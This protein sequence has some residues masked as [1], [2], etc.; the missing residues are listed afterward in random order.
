MT[1]IQSALE[2]RVSFG[3]FPY[4]FA[5]CFEHSFHLIFLG[6]VHVKRS[7]LFLIFLLLEIHQTCNVGNGHCVSRDKLSSV[8]N[9]HCVGQSGLFSSGIELYVS[10][11]AFGT[12]LDVNISD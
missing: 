6:V 5:G 1:E 8:G 9:G 12:E 2:I 7:P 3:K 11:I 4:Q 10:G